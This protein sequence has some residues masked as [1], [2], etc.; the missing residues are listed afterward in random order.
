MPVPICGSKRASGVSC[1]VRLGGGEESIHD[2]GVLHFDEPPGKMRVKERDRQ[3]GALAGAEVEEEGFLRPQEEGAD[4]DRMKLFRELGIR[5][6]ESKLLGLMG[7]EPDP[8]LPGGVVIQTAK[9]LERPQQ[10]RAVHDLVM[11]PDR[12][13]VLARHRC[14]KGLIRH[15]RCLTKSWGCLRR[16][17]HKGLIGVASTKAGPPG[18]MAVTMPADNTR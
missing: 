2:L 11:K 14:Q 13:E 9:L 16:S 10:P 7:V 12:L 15:F 1:Q 18:T 6:L 5:P 3:D 8:A 4:H 17:L